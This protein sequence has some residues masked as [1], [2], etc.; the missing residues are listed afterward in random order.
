MAGK[1]IKSRKKRS[2]SLLKGF[3]YSIVKLLYH[4]ITEKTSK[5]IKMEN[6]AIY[7]NNVYQDW[8]F[9]FGKN[10]CNTERMKLHSPM[11]NCRGELDTIFA[12]ISPP[13]SLY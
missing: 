10:Y 5:C 2:K 7:R 3:E 1:I 13:I 6:R 8:I 11:P 12:Q 9:S 4:C